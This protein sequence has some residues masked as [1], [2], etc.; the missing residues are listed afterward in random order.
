MRGTPAPTGRPAVLDN[1]TRDETHNESY[2]DSRGRRRVQ[3]LSLRG[4]DEELERRIRELARRE[5]ISLN[6]AALK[7]MRQ[8]AGIAESGEGSASVG[9]ALDSFIGRWTEE[10]ERDLLDSIAP[11]EAVDPEL[12][13]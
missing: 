11:C 1:M 13:R 10:D 9:S 7:L 4:F 8:G 3:Q 2:Y 12:W 6:K 5:R